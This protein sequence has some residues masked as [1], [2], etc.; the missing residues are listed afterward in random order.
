M[1][2]VVR[3]WIDEIGC[4]NR[5]EFSPTGN[6]AVDAALRNDVL[7]DKRLSGPP[8]AGMRMPVK[9]RLTATRPQ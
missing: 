9:L 3:I 1:D 5:A 6:A 4:I 7:K 8:P 2:V